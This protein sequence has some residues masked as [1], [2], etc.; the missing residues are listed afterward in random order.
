MLAPTNVT[1]ATSRPDQT[2]PHGD[3]DEQA[4]RRLLRDA[5]QR[6]GYVFIEAGD[7]RQALAAIDIEKPD[8][9]LL[10]LGLLDREGIELVPIIKAKGTSVLVISARDATDEK[11]TALDLGADDDVT[12][13]FDT[14][15]A[16]AR[17]RTALRPKLSANSA[18]LIAVPEDSRAIG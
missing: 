7:A 13:P 4:I 18:A 8:A 3:P 16:L 17:I 6:A 1:A 2:Y 11:V 5:L 12:K 14:E 10:D 9:V 15:E